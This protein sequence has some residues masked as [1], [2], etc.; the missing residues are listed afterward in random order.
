LLEGF[1][2]ATTLTSAVGGG[3]GGGGAI[4]LGSLSDSV[5]NSG[6][7][8]VL[9]GQDPDGANAL[10]GIVDIF[11]S[12]TNTGL[13]QGNLVQ[14]SGFTTDTYALM[15][16][17]GGA[18]AGGDGQ[19][20]GPTTTTPEPAGELLFGAGLIALAFLRRAKRS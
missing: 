19:G 2:I 11:G 6:M 13:V 18:G 5:S 9:G 8:N 3:A 12:F 17:G 10:A 16:G 15:G 20:F 7:I 4:D 1:S 14:S